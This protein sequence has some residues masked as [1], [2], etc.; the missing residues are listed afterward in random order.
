M[1]TATFDGWVGLVIGAAIGIALMFHPVFR[2]PDKP[3]LDS[4]VGK[5][6]VIVCTFTGMIAG[7][8]VGVVWTGVCH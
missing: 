3:Y 1:K 6:V 8:L 4:T 7:E 5:L 2:F